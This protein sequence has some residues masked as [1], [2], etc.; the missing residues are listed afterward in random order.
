MQELLGLA[1]LLF[2]GRGAGQQTPGQAAATQRLGAAAG[3]ASSQSLQGLL[4]LLDSPAV[5]GNL[6]AMCCPDLAA[7]PA[8]ELWA[9]MRAEIQSVEIIHGFPAD[10]SLGGTDNI[11]DVDLEL[12]STLG[13][14]PNQWQIAQGLCPVPDP[15]TSNRS[16]AEGRLEGWLAPADATETSIVG[17]PPFTAP[18]PWGLRG[19]WPASF[20]EASGR[21]TYT[22]LNLHRLDMVTEYGQVRYD[23]GRIH[24][25]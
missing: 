9:R 5:R 3:P 21:V 7:L 8:A 12:M 23:L 14:F 24:R 4:R 11:I 10:A 13:Y 18:N 16:C 19:Q 6:S 2:A 20:A 25:F 22:L 1:L 15:A 17:L